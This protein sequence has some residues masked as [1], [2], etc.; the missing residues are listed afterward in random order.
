MLQDQDLKE[1]ETVITEMETLEQQIAQ[2]KDQRAFIDG[3][4]EQRQRECAA[5]AEKHAERINQLQKEARRARSKK[6]RSKMESALPED[7]P[8]VGSD[9]DASNQEPNRK[10]SSQPL[11]ALDVKV[12]DKALG[13]EMRQKYISDAD[14][15]ETADGQV[16]D[17]RLEAL[18][19]ALQSQLHLVQQLN[20]KVAMHL[21]TMSKL[22]AASSEGSGMK[23][24]E[25]FVQ[26]VSTLKEK[27]AACIGRDAV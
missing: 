20:T 14:V 16:S 19:G 1:I 23:L 21:Q 26:D 9:S 7:L 3:L 22:Q 25:L 4:I 13:V 11:Q 24:R 5:L 8:S 27:V 2:K 12:L 10:V 6:G 18:M 15:A 17:E